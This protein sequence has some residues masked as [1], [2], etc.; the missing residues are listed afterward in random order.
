[1]QGGAPV[2]PLANHFSST[3]VEAAEWIILDSQKD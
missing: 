3:L 2:S 1:V